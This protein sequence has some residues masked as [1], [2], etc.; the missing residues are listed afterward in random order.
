MPGSLLGGK[1]THDC[2]CSRSIGYFL[3][4]IV[5][6]SPFAKSKTQLTLLGVTNDEQDPAVGHLNAVLLL[7]QCP[8][9]HCVLLPT[10]L[11]VDVIRTVTLPLLRR[12]GVEDG[13]ELKVRRA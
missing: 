13:L 10:L 12:F 5:C 11:Q 7:T 8:A 9:A 2:G 3:E 6:L 1:I 4:S